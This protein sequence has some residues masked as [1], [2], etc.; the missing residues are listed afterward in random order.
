MLGLEASQDDITA[1]TCH[2]TC[3]TAE[4]TSRQPHGRAATWQ[5]ALPVRKA[6]SR[7]HRMRDMRSEHKRACDGIEC[8]M[9]GGCALRQVEES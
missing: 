8:N 7:R 3:A 2:R 1:Q 5:R 6:G 4:L 9:S